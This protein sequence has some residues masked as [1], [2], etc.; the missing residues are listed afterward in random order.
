MTRGTAAS[1]KGVKHLKPAIGAP[2]N[3]LLFDLQNVF[4]QQAL[5]KVMHKLEVKM[6]VAI[7]HVVI[8]DTCVIKSA[9]D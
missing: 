1:S 4:C 5:D 6:A 9:H 8:T 2:C 7:M 3:T